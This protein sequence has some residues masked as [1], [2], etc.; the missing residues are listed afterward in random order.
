MDSITDNCHRDCQNKYF[1]VSEYKCVHVIKIRNNKI[2][3]IVNLT[4]ADKSMNLYEL[5]KIK[6]CTREMF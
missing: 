3:G 1:Q 4:I 5:K 2:N 6:T